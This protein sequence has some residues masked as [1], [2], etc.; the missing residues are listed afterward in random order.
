M[1][2]R[3]FV[4]CKPS[5]DED[6]TPSTPTIN[7]I[8]EDMVRVIYS[9]RPRGEVEERTDTYIVGKKT[10]GLKF[11]KEVKLELKKLISCSDLGVEEYKKIKYGKK[12]LKKYEEDIIEEICGIGHQDEGTIRRLLQQQQQLQIFKSRTITYIGSITLEVVDLELVAPCSL[13]KHWCSLAIESEKALDIQSFVASNALVRRLL[14]GVNSYIAQAQLTGSDHYIFPLL[15]GYPGWILYI[16]ERCDPS[17]A[18][19][20]FKEVFAKLLR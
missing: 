4:P 7:A 17:I 11:R 1:E 2:W 8:V 18:K 3:I 5:G 15:G 6:A 20:S 13:P 16:H 9:L 12:G 19:D 10:F 14:A